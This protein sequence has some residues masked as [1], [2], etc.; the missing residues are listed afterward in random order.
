MMKHSRLLTVLDL[1]II[2][3]C[4]IVIGLGMAVSADLGTI[5]VA[6][7]A[8]IFFA[9]P[10]TMPLA[11]GVGFLAAAVGTWRLPFF[12]WSFSGAYLCEKL[13]RPAIFSLMGF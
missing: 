7:A 10:F 8:F 6:F 11:I 12:V 4:L 1:A 5:V 3:P 9:L 13:L 2:A